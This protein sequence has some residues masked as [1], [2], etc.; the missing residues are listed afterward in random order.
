MMPPPEKRTPPGKGGVEERQE[1]AENT[2]DLDVRPVDP[3]LGWHSLAQK[4]IGRAR[5]REQRRGRR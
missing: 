4:A 5:R 3:V 1:H 2:G